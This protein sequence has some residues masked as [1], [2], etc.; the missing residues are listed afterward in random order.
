[1]ELMQAKEL[2]LELLCELQQPSARRD[3]K[4]PEDSMPSIDLEHTKSERTNGK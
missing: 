2:Q 3:A 1:M 4:I